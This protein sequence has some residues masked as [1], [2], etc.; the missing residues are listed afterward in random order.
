[1]RSKFKS[2]CNK[3]HYTI[4]QGEWIRYTGKAYHLDCKEALVDDTPRILNPK[5]EGIFGK[6]QKDKLRKKIRHRA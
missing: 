1:M 5:F 3:C 4:W 2:Y 6:I